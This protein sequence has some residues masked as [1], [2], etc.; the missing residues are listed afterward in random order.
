MGHPKLRDLLEN[1]LPDDDAFDNYEVEHDFPDLGHRTMVLNARRVDHMQLILL[2]IE[3]Q[4]EVRRASRALRESEARLSSLMRHAPIGIGLVDREGRWVLQNP[5]LERLSSGLIP[6]RDPEQVRLW[7]PA[8]ETD[9]ENWPAARALRREVVA[10]G[11]DFRK[12]I[13][14]QERW[15]RISAAPVEDTEEVE[16]AVVIVEDVTEGK[17]AEE[18]R[19][20]LLGELNHRVKNLFGVI[21]SLV[22][23]RSGS[24]EAEE[25]KS[26]LEG[27]SGRARQSPLAGRST[28]AGAAS[29]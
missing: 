7:R 13:D 17:E 9:P 25:Y 20:L 3:D 15:L 23:Q 16:H 26:T 19:E 14:G 2:A 12:E 5:L 21:R 18:E 27:P 29:T 10:P 28:A 8:D 22:S 4:T 1:V 24:P 6:S 11:V